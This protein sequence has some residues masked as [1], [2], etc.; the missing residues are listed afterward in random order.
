MLLNRSLIALQDVFAL[1]QPFIIKSK[2]CLRFERFQ[3]L[4][5]EK[6]LTKKKL[7]EKDV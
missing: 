5:N 2:I 1:F 7:G 3:K 6:K 4:H